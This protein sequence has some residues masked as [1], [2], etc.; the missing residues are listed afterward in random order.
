MKLLMQEIPKLCLII[1][2]YSTLA[3]DDYGVLRPTKK[4]LRL[5]QYG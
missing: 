3:T 2:E 5:Y 4:H 1:V